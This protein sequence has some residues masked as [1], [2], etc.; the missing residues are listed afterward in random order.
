METWQILNKEAITTYDALREYIDLPSY[1]SPFPKFPLR[2]PKRI[3]EKFTSWDDPLFRQFVPTSEEL[4]AH[5][6]FTT[7]PVG[8]IEATTGT[9]VL[10]KY[11][12]RSL[13][14]AT[15][16]CAMHCRYCFRQSYP[17]SSDEIDLS[18]LTE[19]IEEVILSGG[20][21]LSLPDPALRR[22][23][24]RIDARTHVKVIR[25][26]TRFPIGIPE[27]ITENFLS[28]LSSLRSQV[29]FVIHSNHAKEFDDDI[30]AALKQV[31]SLG[32]PL[33]NQSVLLKG[34][35]DSIEALRDLSLVLIRNGII[36]YYLHQLDKVKGAAHFEVPVEE[37]LTLVES[38]RN[39]LPGYAIPTYVQEEKGK[40][41][42]T[43]LHLSENLHTEEIESF[44]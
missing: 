15:S 3:A 19:D 26:H 4:V 33:L 6:G 29:V 28:I 27:R 16:A 34:V 41:C 20:D 32:I 10:S 18:S 35:N 7:N 22:L 25:F 30:F 43:A 14:I 1:L 17:Y 31:G 13:L 5:P 42:K 11:P 9:R 38:L 36:P 24:L 23:L 40:P 21:P 44:F 12:R 8:D 37:G 39:E 2:I